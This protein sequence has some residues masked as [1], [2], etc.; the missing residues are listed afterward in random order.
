MLRFAA[1]VKKCAFQEMS[2]FATTERL[3]AFHDFAFRTCTKTA[4]LDNDKAFLM[5]CLTRFCLMRVFRNVFV[6]INAFFKRVCFCFKRD[7]DKDKCN[8]D[9]GKCAICSYPC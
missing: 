5:R 4:K 3:L 6:C 1:Y 7:K 2:H 8:K 9:K